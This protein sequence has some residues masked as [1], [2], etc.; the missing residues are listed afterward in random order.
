MKKILTSLLLLASV[1]PAFASDT[2]V[3]S[4][5]AIELM[6]LLEIR[7]NIDASTSQVLA[8]TERMIESQNLPPEA[9]ALAKQSSRIGS[10]VTLDA[11]K[12]MEWEVMFADIYAQV[13]SA[14]EIQG[15]I[16]FYGTPLGQKLLEKQPELMAATMQKM[17]VEMGKFMPQIQAA[18]M[19]AIEKA[20]AS[21]AQEIETPA[22]ESAE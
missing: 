20:K 19:Q 9:E 13:F 8:F 5:K 16:D 1:L 7:K 12:N 18:A 11:M 2:D 10:Q 14:E 22:V 15:L 6:Q 17:Q 21:S 4:E 3:A